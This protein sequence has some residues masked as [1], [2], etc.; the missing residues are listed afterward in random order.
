MD[1]T[2]KT[3]EIA[4]HEKK[5]LPWELIEEIL[6]RVSPIS[7]VRFKT[8]CKRWKAILDDKTFINNHKETFRFILKSKSKIYSVS[9][10]PKIVVRE[11]TLD[12]PGLESQKPKFWIDYDEF[13][14]CHTDKGTAVWNPWLKQISTCIKHP[15]FEFVGICYDGSNWTSIWGNYNVW[16]IHDYAFVAWKH[17]TS[18]DCDER[19]IQLKTMHSEIGGSLN[20]SLFWIAYRDETDPLYCL[21]RFDF[22]KERFY[23]FCDLP[24]GMTHPRDA[25]VVRFFKGDRFSVLKQCHVTKK[26][27]IWVTKNKVNVEDG[28]DVVWVSFMT[29]SIPNFPSLV[30]AEP[31]SDQQPSYYID[32]KRLVMCSCDENGQAWIYVL[33]E[34]KLI[35]IVQLDSVVDPWPSHCTYFPSLVPVPREKKMKQ[36]YKFNFI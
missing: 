19:K 8:V 25:L 7:L 33:G 22:Y 21:C 24:C 2:K 31:Y 27:E 11:L 16:I 4:A 14:I 9:I 23:T 13:M 18:G 15:R 29:F 12:V 1:S 35:S 30:Q 36:N 3:E 26:I 34:N 32:N 28:R 17:V 6:S 20:G 10:D 5:H